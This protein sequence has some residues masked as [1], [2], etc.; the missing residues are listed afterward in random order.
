M[1]AAL[2]LYALRPAHAPPADVV[3]VGCAEQPAVTVTVTVTTP[4]DVGPALVLREVVD[5]VVERVVVEDDDVDVLRVV[6]DE[7]VDLGVV[8]EEDVELRDVVDDET[9]LARVLLDVDVERDVDDTVERDVVDD[10]LVEL[11]VVPVT[12]VV[13]I[14][15]LPGPRPMKLRTLSYIE[16][17]QCVSRC[18][19]SR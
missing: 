18:P 2:A 16:P 15:V 13:G 6:V 12:V 4:V 17:R 7:E 10:V 5:E 3:A 11:A 9:V 19:V 8:V 14:V 1:Y